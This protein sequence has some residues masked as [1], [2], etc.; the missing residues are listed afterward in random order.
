MSGSFIGDVA[1][2][3]LGSAPAKTKVIGINKSTAAI[4]PRP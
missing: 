3:D 2:G 1:E 4:P